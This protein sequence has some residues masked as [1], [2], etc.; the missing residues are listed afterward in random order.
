MISVNELPTMDFHFFESPNKI[1]ITEA[2]FNQ[3]I[4][5]ELDFNFDF[6]F[7]LDSKSFDILKKLS[8]DRTIRKELNSIIIDSKEG[9]YKCSMMD[10]VKPEL[11]LTEVLYECKYDSSMLKE[12]SKFVSDNKALAVLNG[13]LFNDIG[14]VFASDTVK[15]FYFRP[16]IL[17]YS[18]FWS[19]PTYFIGMLPQQ[20]IT[21]KF[22]DTKVFC[23]G[24]FNMYSSLYDG[25]VPAIERVCDEFTSDKNITIEKRNELGLLESESVQFKVERDKTTVIFDDNE[26]IFKVEYYINSDFE[27][28]AK[29][30]F[31]NF[32]Q[33]LS[34]VD[35][36]MFIE[37]G[38]KSL[39]INNKFIVGYRR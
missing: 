17:S 20:E 39:R 10:K 8:T 37:F 15:F 36:K 7:I 31:N 1:M 12:A 25:R 6:D 11:K 32:Y 24:K 28:L 2:S 35:D 19:V 30:G 29:T 13:I 27:F 23:E 16:E 33:V 18:R 26:K 5:A 9:R 21:L 4:T 34:I 22:T 38:E 14:N 3:I